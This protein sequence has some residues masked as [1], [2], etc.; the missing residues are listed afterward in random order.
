MAKALLPGEGL[1][2]PVLAFR[3]T[4]VVHRARRTSVF[5]QEQSLDWSGGRCWSSGRMKASLLF[6]TCEQVV[7]ERR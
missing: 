2:N 6:S 5:G 7:A 3:A 1:S 4:R